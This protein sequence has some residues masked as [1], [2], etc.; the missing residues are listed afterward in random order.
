MQT[1][2]SRFRCGTLGELRNALEHLQADANGADDS[3]IYIRNRDGDESV[4]VSIYE[5]TLSDGSLVY[6]LQIA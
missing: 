1:L 4:R 5:E 6:N 2:L 3:T